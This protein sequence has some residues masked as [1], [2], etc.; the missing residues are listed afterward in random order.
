[1]SNQ[2][3]LEN[4][5]Q[6]RRILTDGAFGTYFQSICTE[7]IFP[8]Q[9]NISRPDLVKKVHLA[10][11]KAGARLIRTNTF[12]ANTDT[13]SGGIEGVVEV[14]KNAYRIADEA[15]REYI[16]T[17]QRNKAREDIFIAGDIGPITLSNQD[18]RERVLDEYM[19]IADTFL[20]LGVD[21]ILFETFPSL[22]LIDQVI[23][24]IREKSNVFIW[25]SMSVNQTGYSQ[26]GI[27]L[28]FLLKDMQTMS[29]I[30]AIGFNCG[31]GPGHMHRSLKMEAL[32]GKK[33]EWKDKFISV[34]PNASYPRIVRGQVVFTK[35]DVYFAD[36]L[37]EIAGMGASIIGGCC[38]TTPDTIAMVSQKLKERPELWEFDKKAFISCQ[39]DADEVIT[40]ELNGMP[41][42][43]DINMANPEKEKPWFRNPKRADGKL[44]AVELSPPPNAKDDKV[45]NAA[46]Y[47]KDMDIDVV[48][49]PDSPSGR[50]RA[51]SI[52]MA[53]KVKAKTDIRV[54][55]HICC[56]DKN[57]IAIRAQLLGAH[58]SD[59]R[60][61]LVIT[62]DPI[63]TMAREQVKSVFNFDAVGLMKIIDQINQTEFDG[64]P[65]DMLL[66]YG[67][68]INQNKYNLESEIR[69]VSRKM[70]AGA[71]YFLSQ[72][73]FT[74]KEADRLRLIKERTGATILCGIM[75][76]ISR[77]NALFIQNEM[78]GMCV[79][80]EI[81]SWFKEEST[82]QEG[83]AV[84]V[85]LAREMM[86]LTGDFADGFYFSIPFNRVYLLTEILR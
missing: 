2:V 19:Q 33:G 60:D 11:L 64:Q 57:A 12:A 49:F 71:S 5:L 25:V 1:M 17:C 30:N 31:V 29:Q 58:M 50:T 45:L 54:M 80:D 61:F 41:E 63:P 53:A 66:H 65:S 18:D 13:I 10:Y 46:Y 56:R 39:P 23:V 7:D 35:N 44:I 82:R 4:Y 76:L 14:C 67:G 28:P 81:V 75:P 15:R 8:E 48:T 26:A 74:G 32:F 51:D 68:A 21:A 59:I 37:L 6:N 79:T 40:A 24:K 9:A 42:H 52:L 36:K 38:G 78:S 47:L 27:S 62:G 22:D 70:E 69:R 55:P 34:L 3:T 16:E 85:A 73:I 84:G 77:K 72:P 86:Q 43:A 83:E 20:S